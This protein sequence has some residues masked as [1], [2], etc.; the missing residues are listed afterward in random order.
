MP[1]DPTPPLPGSIRLLTWMSLFLI[2][3]ILILSLLDF[4][5][6]SCFIN[7]IA[8]VLNMIYHLTVLLATHFRPAKAAAFTVTAISLG[9]LLSLTW[10]SAF[11]V[12]VF[13]ALKGGAA[14]DLFGLDIQFSNTVI[15][16]QRIQLLFTML[17]FAIMVDL[18][19]RSTLKRRK[20]HENT[21]TY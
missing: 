7:P 4:G 1:P 5:L 8:A 6:L 3:M 14:C 12:M 15:S 2:L 13:V 11:L 18:S 19:I 16:T 20:R 21:I 10:L 17:E 9:F